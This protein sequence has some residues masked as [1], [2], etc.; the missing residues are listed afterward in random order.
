[1]ITT[2]NRNTFEN[3]FEDELINARLFDSLSA[4][5]LLRREAEQNQS[6]LSATSNLKTDCE[7]QSE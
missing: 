1:M 7:H 4:D 6:H 2:F 5:Y 3:L